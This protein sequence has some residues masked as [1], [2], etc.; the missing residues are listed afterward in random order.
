M[1]NHPNRSQIDTATVRVGNCDI[2][3]QVFPIVTERDEQVRDLVRDVDPLPLAKWPISAIAIS[4]RATAKL[5]ASGGNASSREDCEWAMKALEL[6]L[7]VMIRPATT[8]AMR[9]SRHADARRAYLRGD[10][11]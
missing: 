10:I 11:R 2:A 3:T 1:T 7:D 6:D 9:Q 4:E 8:A 5:L